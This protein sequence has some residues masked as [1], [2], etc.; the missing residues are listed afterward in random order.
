MKEFIIKTL[1]TM[2]LFGIF[3]LFAFA[4]SIAEDINQL[5]VLGR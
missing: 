2:L 4:M 1:Q 3:C 5:L